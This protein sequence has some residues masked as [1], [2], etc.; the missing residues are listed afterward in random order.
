MAPSFNYPV[1]SGNRKVTPAA[2]RLAGL[3]AAAAVCY[4]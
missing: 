3:T 2:G 4:R 1:K